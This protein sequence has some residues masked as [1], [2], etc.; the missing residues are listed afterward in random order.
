MRRTE[1]KTAGEQVLLGDPDLAPKLAASLLAAA[2]VDRTT[3]GLHTWP[4]GLHPD[5]AR[6]LVAAFPSRSVLDPFCGGGTV[7]IEALAAGRRAVGRD[8]SSIAVRVSRLR[9]ELPNE[10][11]LTA[12]RSAARRIADV[13]KAGREPPPEPIFKAVR[14]WYAPHVLGELEAIRQGCLG[15]DPSIREPLLTLFSSILIK[16]SYRKSDTSQQREPTDRP[17]GTTSVLFHK[18][19][20]EY[21]RRI[22]ALREVVPEGTPPS[23]VAFGDARDVR[24]G[25]PVDL[26][27]TSPP[28]PSTYDYLPLQH[29]RR[30]WLGLREPD[31]DEIASRRSWRAGEKDARKRW[32]SDTFA[33][34]QSAAAALAPG[35]H[36]VV[37]IGD[38]L[39]P[40]GLV[41]TSEPTE[42]AAKNA[43]LVA[44]A[45]ASVE[46]PDFARDTMR[47]E[48]AFAF[49]KG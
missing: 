46:R 29:L 12:I 28:Y 20:R 14:E 16:T 6:D 21:G 8:L 19:A 45:R 48:H 3:H 27:L 23:D 30:V 15:A 33:W 36:L 13:A 25:A 1:G 2:E 26:V 47:W 41:D 11:L 38:G 49:R 40:G 42:A 35:G 17:R 22:T 44:V 39:A 7:L 5:A 37:V 24:I 18:K 31:D 9:T 43:G 34:T 4:A 32:R 10:A